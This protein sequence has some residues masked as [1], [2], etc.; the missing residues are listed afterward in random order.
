MR[1]RGEAF[2]CVSLEVKNMVGVE[3]ALEK[4]TEKEI[5]EGYS[6]DDEV[7]H[8]MCLFCPCRG[9]PGTEQQEY[10]VCFRLDLLVHVSYLL[11]STKYF[12]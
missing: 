2:M 7:G 10:L 9:A 5:I 6:W 1:E 3:D 11:R 8:G 12:V 4:F